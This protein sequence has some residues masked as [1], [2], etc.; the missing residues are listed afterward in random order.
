MDTEGF[1][2]DFETCEVPSDQRRPLLTIGLNMM[3]GPI[4]VAALLLGSSLAQ[5]LAFKDCFVAVLCAGAVLSIYGGL[6][7]LV[8]TRR[9]LASGMLVRETFGQGGA[10]LL[11]AV[12]A[13]SLGGWYAVQT[14]M[15]GDVIATLFPEGGFITNPKVAAVWGGLLMLST[16]L[17]GFRGLSLLSLVSVPLLVILTGFGVWRVITGHDVLAFIPPT[18]GNISAIITMLIGAFSVGATITADVTR[19]SRNGRES[20]AACVAAYLVTN[21]FML[22]SGAA[23]AMATGSGDLLAAMVALGMGLPALF[24]LIAGQW[25]T[26]DDNLYSASLAVTAAFPKVSKSVV[27]VV[28]GV[29]ATVLATLGVSNLFVPLLM[30]LGVTIPPIGGVLIADQLVVRPRTQRERP[31]AVVAFLSWGVGILA[32]YFIPIGIPALNAIGSAFAIFLIAS[33]ARSKR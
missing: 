18:P 30:T 14:A 8:G 16:A 11:G 6:L 24:I 26:N 10:I 4:C 29:T 31:A 3:G 17:F 7:G 28:I 9:G 33:L 27:V 22:L 21:A 19:F 12:V 13:I 2:K 23:I 32:G 20:W 15:F 25:T 1:A 5:S